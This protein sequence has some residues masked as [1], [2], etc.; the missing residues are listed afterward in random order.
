MNHFTV[1][2]S[3]KKHGADMAG[4]KRNYL[5]TANDGTQ[6]AITADRSNI[7]AVNGSSATP[8]TTAAEGKY[9]TP[10]NLRIRQLTYESP[11]KTRR[12]V[13]AALTP[14]IYDAPPS[15]IDDPLATG[16][17]TLS[18]GNPIPERIRRYSIADTGRDATS[19]SGDGTVSS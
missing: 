6:Y 17:S 7:L 15:T 2:Y 10:K 16:S 13:V 9:G 12:I 3:I 5:Y 11:D 4:S 1:G 14:E 18:V 19:D 8:I